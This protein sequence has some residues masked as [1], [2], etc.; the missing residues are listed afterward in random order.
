MGLNEETNLAIERAHREGVLTDA[1][2]MMGQAGAAHALEVIRRNP[3]LHIGWHVHIC[4][5]TPLTCPQ[6][7]WGNSPAKAGIATGVFPG[8][9]ALIRRELQAQ[10]NAFQAAGV[11][12][13]FINGHHHLHIHPFVCSEILKLVDGSFTGWVRGFGL[14]FFNPETQW[15]PTGAYRLLRGGANY[16]LRSW[17]ASRRSDTLWG[18]DRNFAMQADEVAAVLPCLGSGR[19]EFMFHPRRDQD[20]DQTALLALRKMNLPQVADP[21]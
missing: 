18:I 5:S 21:L 4:D 15:Q 13:R 19:H 10:W 16:W 7:S 12:C 8:A 14:R 1:S 20:A 11:P 2:L 17:P 9:R 6:W 3:E